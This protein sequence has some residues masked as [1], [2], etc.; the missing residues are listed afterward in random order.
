MEGPGG[1]KTRIFPAAILGG[2]LTKGRALAAVGAATQLLMVTIQLQRYDGLANARTL[3]E[4]SKWHGLQV[5]MGFIQSSGIPDGKYIT[6]DIIGKN[7]Q[8]SQSKQ[9]RT[10]QWDVLLLSETWR[11]KRQER[12]RTGSG[13]L[14]CGLSRKRSASRWREK[15]SVSCDLSRSAMDISFLYISRRQREGMFNKS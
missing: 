9:L 10:I 13:H 3:M 15:G 5:R 4:I 12:W 6:L 7:V 8:S 14:F 1:V 2:V 11:A